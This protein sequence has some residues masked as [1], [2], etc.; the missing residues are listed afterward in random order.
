MLGC[1]RQVEPLAATAGMRV[2]GLTFPS[3]KVFHYLP[4]SCLVRCA[5]HLWNR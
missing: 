2:V 1:V 3:V 5:G 4:R